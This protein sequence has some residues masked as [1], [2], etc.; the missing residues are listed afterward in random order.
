ML[1][2]VKS[3][4]DFVIPPAL[5]ESATTQTVVKKRAPGFFA[6]TFLPGI[7][8]PTRLCCEK[9]GNMARKTFGG[10]KPPK[11]PG[12][13]VPRPKSEMVRAHLGPMQGKLIM[14]YWRRLPCK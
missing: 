12:V 3:T 2:E 6:A 11:P 4:Q 8:L 14:P 1:E 13:C 7:R 9:G 5:L 10:I